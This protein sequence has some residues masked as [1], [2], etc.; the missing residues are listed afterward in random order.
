M[1]KTAIIA[2]AAAW[3]LL[4][5]SL[6][7]R[8]EGQTCAVDAASIIFPAPQKACLGDPFKIPHIVK[9]FS[10]TKQFTKKNIERFD[11]ALSG[12]SVKLE[13]SDAKSAQLT[14]SE[15]PDSHAGAY[16]DEGYKI[17]VKSSPFSIEIAARSET[18]FIYAALTIK[19]MMTASG[20]APAIYSGTIDDYP[21]FSLR[22]VLEGGYDVWSYENR[23][24]IIKW[25]PEQKFNFFIYAPKDDPYFRRQW[26]KPYPPEILDQFKT[27]IKICNEYNVIFSFALSPAMSMEYSNPEEFKKLVDKYRQLQ[28][29]GVSSFGIF[30][31]DVLPYLSTPNDK[32]TFK[33]VAEAEVYVTNKLLTALREKD[34]G[35]KLYF[36]PN[37]YWGWTPTVYMSVIKEKLNH[38][39]EVGW[40]GKE[41]CSVSITPADAKKFLEVA[42]RAPA[43]GD[44]YSPLAP[45]LNRA[46]DLYTA[47][48]SFVNN[49][50]MFTSDKNSEFSKFVNATIADYTWNPVGYDANRSFNNAA[51]RIAGGET[52][53]DALVLALDLVHKTGVKSRCKETLFILNEQL[54]NA[55]ATDTAS[56]IAALRA[57]LEKYTGQVSDLKK[58][59]FTPIF[60]AQSASTIDGAVSRLD[61]AISLLQKN[62]PDQTTGQLADSIKKTLGL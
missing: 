44:N 49:P 19:D 29:L 23:L 56:I 38:E 47:V 45:L 6:A 46:P 33:N 24:E 21:M 9:Y 4:A 2:A 50:Y 17:T 58:A 16:R 39:I 25:L 52:A 20:G 14:F 15:S 42:G 8:A 11:S 54:R 1:K 55:P 48:T 40:T 31:D 3:L 61:A 30:F 51:R 26:R 59:P 13:K 27:Y 35:A 53:G 36:V 32:K 5:A 62:T 43:V 18:G 12:A 34:P 57:E 22:G 41:I 28:A 37:Q 7:A 60:A 10:A